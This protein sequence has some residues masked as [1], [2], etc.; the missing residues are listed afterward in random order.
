MGDY[1]AWSVFFYFQY[2]T[3][4]F[5]CLFFWQYPFFAMN[6][7]IILNPFAVLYSCKEHF[8]TYLVHDSHH[9]SNSRWD[10]GIWWD[11]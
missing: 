3:F 1:L 4:N 9:R 8:N 5:F 6:N 7:Y 2:F 10:V 11:Q